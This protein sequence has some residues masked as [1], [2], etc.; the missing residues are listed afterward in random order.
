[1]IN[2]ILIGPPGAGK[3]TQA[4]ILVDRLGLKQ[5][6]TGDLLRAEVAAGSELGQR[7][8]ATMD[9]GGIV[10]DA[11]MIR[12]VR[13]RIRQADCAQGV[14]FDG[15]P[16][17]VPQAQALDQMMVDLGLKIDAIIQIK[18]DGS[19]LL[20]RIQERA[21]TSGVVRSDD[22]PDVLAK[23][24]EGYR[25]QTAPVL[26]HYQAAGRLSVVDGM[27]AIDQVAGAIA[28]LLP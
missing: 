9:A 22:N 20:A 24:L 11:T 26:A 18:V 14:I 10:D 19:A 13:H 4:K 12:L 15:F 21:A 3:G 5:I 25:T 17:T 2:I 1:M 28:G 6:S 23:R 16:R 27:Q 7:V 8:K